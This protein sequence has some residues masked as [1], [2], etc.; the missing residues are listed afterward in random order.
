M[1]YLIGVGLAVVVCAFATWV[2][3]DRDRVFYPAMVIVVATYYILFAVMG[4][5]KPAL[6]LESL[7]A[8]AFLALAVAGFKKNL[9]LAAAALAGHGVFDFF[10]H[11]LIQNPGVPAW[12]PGFCLSFDVLAGV[13][14]AILLLRRSGFASTV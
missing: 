10:H 12:W 8:A 2:G 4:S 5:S 14:L 9:W 3:F 13:F 7:V 11:L 1:E 6:A